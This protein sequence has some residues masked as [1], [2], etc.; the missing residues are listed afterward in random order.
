MSSAWLL[1]PEHIH[2]ISATGRRGRKLSWTNS[3]GDECS[4]C[5]CLVSIFRLREEW[6]QKLETKLRL[7]NN[8]EDTEKRTNV[9]WELPASLTQEDTKHWGHFARRSQCKSLSPF[10]IPVSPHTIVS[11]ARRGFT[12]KCFPS[13]WW[14]LLV[15]SVLCA[16]APGY[17]PKC[18]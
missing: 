9:G 14:Q 15:K 3:R 10:A 18:L 6:K 4:I 17:Y 7:R 1:K 8:P 2:V 5:V 12:C 13:A 11:P 16:W